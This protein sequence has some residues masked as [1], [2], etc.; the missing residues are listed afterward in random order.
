M[1]DDD[2]IFK[3]GSKG[4][5]LTVL[6]HA[7]CLDGFGA[8]WAVWRRWPDATFIPVAY[9]KPL[10][11]I[12]PGTDVVIVDFS[13]P[14]DTLTELAERVNSVLVL[15]HHQTA[16]AQLQSLPDASPARLLPTRG[17]PL[18]PW[19][20]FQW[21][22]A[23]LAAWFDMTK[24]GCRLAWEFFHPGEDLPQLL[25]HLEDRDLWKFR[26][27]GTKEIYA[28]VASYS[29]AFS[30]WDEL[31]T[32]IE[33]DSLG[34]EDNRLLGQGEALL[35]AF[36]KQVEDAVGASRRKLVIGGY[37]VHVANVPFFMA[38]DAGEL[39]GRGQVFAATYYDAQDG[40]K[41][42]LRSEPGGL[43]VSK[44]AK[45]YGG[46]GHKHAAGF[47][48]EKGWEGDLLKGVL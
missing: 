7:G 5:R 20:E 11:E 6:Y 40:R 28:A 25:V 2:V 12:R 46:G 17:Q 24:S 15:D 19:T 21:S 32:M 14:F 41:F 18:D 9:G 33:Y 37:L 4:D 3:D 34:S 16:Q 31:A 29:Q 43:D 38:S 48:A 22:A 45:E 39:L 1:S 44:I 42:S 47:T 30:V 13:Y 8:A 27:P 35:R 10:P 36:D 26:V 23:K